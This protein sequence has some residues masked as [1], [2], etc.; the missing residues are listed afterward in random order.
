MSSYPEINAF[1]SYKLTEARMIDS[2]IYMNYIIDVGIVIAKNDNKVDVQHAALPVLINGKVLDPSVT[3]DVEILYPATNALS[4]DF[5]IKV[6]DVVLLVG[7]KD[8]IET[9]QG[10]TAPTIPQGFSHYDRANLK[11]IPFGS[12]IAP[13]VK[14]AVDDTG[15]FSIDAQAGKIAIKNSVKSLHTVLNNLITHITAFAGG[16][17]AS[18]GAPLSSAA[19]EIPHLIQDAVDLALLLED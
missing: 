10:V 1:T 7:T 17:V 2:R 4:I 14:I 3:K 5:N 13:L 12:P 8:Y 19:T 18:I 6:G 9:L 11:A 15:N 16:T